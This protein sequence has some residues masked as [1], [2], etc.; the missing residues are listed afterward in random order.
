MVKVR[1]MGCS[2]NPGIPVGQKEATNETHITVFHY[3]IVA[4]HNNAG[5]HRNIQTNERLSLYGP[6][7]ERAAALSFDSSNNAKNEKC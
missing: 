5:P 7:A 2:K 4:T 3:T 6:C 1:T